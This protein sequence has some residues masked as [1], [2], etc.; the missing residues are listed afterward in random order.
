MHVESMW[1]LSYKPLEIILNQLVFSVWLQKGYH[2][3]YSKKRGQ[4]NIDKLPS[5][6]AT[7]NLWENFWK[8]NVS[9][10]FWNFFIENKLI[11]S[12]IS[13]F[14]RG[15]PSC[16]NQLLSITHEI[17]SP[18]D[19]GLEGRSVF[20]NIK[21]FDEVWRGGIIFKVTQKTYQEIY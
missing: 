4:T 10:N 15:D 8:T 12:S 1:S 6:V 20:R 14:K 5:S 9:C 11:S 17:Y 19:E 13:G 2:C 3:S 7:T 16:I 18:F 21:A